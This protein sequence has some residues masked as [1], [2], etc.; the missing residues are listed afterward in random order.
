MVD[1]GTS[2]SFIGPNKVIKNGLKGDLGDRHPGPNS[3]TGT[4]SPLTSITSSLAIDWVIIIIII[5]IPAVM[6]IPKA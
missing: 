5:I 1:S 2:H 4:T 6:R 3:A